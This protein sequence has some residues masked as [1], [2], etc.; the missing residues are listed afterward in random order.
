MDLTIK[1][2][3]SEYLRLDRGPEGMIDQKGRSTA[4]AGMIKA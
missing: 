3:G 2:R 4:I 1:T